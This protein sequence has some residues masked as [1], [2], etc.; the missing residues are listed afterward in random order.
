MEDAT[1]ADIGA[2]LVPGQEADGRCAIALLGGVGSAPS[3]GIS[4][5]EGIVDGYGHLE[6]FPQ[7]FGGVGKILLGRRHLRRS[8]KRLDDGRLVP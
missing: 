8:D 5:T 6:R 4:D 1:G 3:D 7:E 2:D